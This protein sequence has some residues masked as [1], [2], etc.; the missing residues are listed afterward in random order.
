MD[1]PWNSD[2]ASKGYEYFDV[3]APEI[4]THYG[5]V[6]WTDQGVTP[7][8][9]DIVKRFDGKVIAIQG[10]EQDQ[11]M[12]SPVGSPGLNP[13]KDVSVPINWAYNH[14]Y[15][16]YMGGK[17]SERKE[18]PT[19]GDV[20]GSGA[21][22]QPTIMATVD[23]E[24]Q[25]GRKFADVAQTKWFISEGNGGESRKSFHG[26]PA[27]FAQLMESPQNWHITPMQIDTRNREHGAQPTDVHKCT[28]MSGVG[29]NGKKC[30]GYEPRQAR[31]G[32]GWK[33]ATVM[34]AYN[35]YNV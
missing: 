20:Y 21:H 27:G 19:P 6:F 25:S 15:C 23:K 13:E 34:R 1:T 11:V 5:Q 35:I 7:L 8:P 18:I 16:A 33:S 30:V 31:Y 9:P 24:D 32:R 10:Y 22:G 17:H 3:W 28:N 2:Y 4:A 12:V 29:E 26:Y 14:H